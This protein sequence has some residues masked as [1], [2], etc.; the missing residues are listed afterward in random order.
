M[1]INELVIYDGCFTWEMTQEVIKIGT[2][3]KVEL[4]N[5]PPIL[6]DKTMT[7]FPKC[8]VNLLLNY[9]YSH[10]HIDEMLI[11]SKI[12]L[13]KFP[14]ISVLSYALPMVDLIEND[15][16]TITSTLKQFGKFCKEHKV[17][18]RLIAQSGLLYKDEDIYKIGDLCEQA[19]I[20]ALIVDQP[21]GNFG[22][23]I[24]LSHGLSKALSIPVG[25]MADCQNDNDMETFINAAFP[26]KI[27]SGENILEL[28]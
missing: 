16:S 11:L 15:W 27:L 6:L 1:N 2:K 20:S 14:S 17:G 22:D 19:D 4:I 18:S 28:E 9:P 24:L 12:Y 8:K 3:Y 13:K 21:A 10:Y 5:L 26:I 7:H 25:I 23:F